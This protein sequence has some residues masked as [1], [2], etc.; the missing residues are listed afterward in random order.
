M[1]VDFPASL[2]GQDPVLLS[3]VSGD[4]GRI[5]HQQAQAVARPTTYS[6]IVRIVRF[7]QENQMPLA[8]RGQ[9][10]SAFGQAQVSQ[11]IVIDSRSLRKIHNID[12]NENSIVVDAGTTWRQVVEHTL[13]YKKQPK[14]LA[15]YLDLS[16]GGV[17]SVGG[18]GGAA[19][20]HGTVADNVL[21][22]Q[23]VTGEGQL[24]E[25]SP[26]KNSEL[27]WSVLGGLGQFGL[28]VQAKIKLCE[29][30][31]HVIRYRLVYRDLR[32]Y[33]DAHRTAIQEQNFL[34]LEGYISFTSQYGWIYRL[35]AVLPFIDDSISD[36]SR[37]EKK[38]KPSFVGVD[39]MS[40]DT[41]LNRVGDLSLYW[42]EAETVCR[43]WFDVFLPNSTIESF[44]SIALQELESTGGCLALS[45]PFLHEKLTCPFFRTPSEKIVWTFDILRSSQSNHIHINE[46]LVKN[47]KLFELARDLGGYRYPISAIPFEQ[48]DWER[49]YGELWY[50]FRERK[51]TYDPNN[52][53]TPGQ[54]IKFQ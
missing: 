27:F 3:E 40:Y 24:K 26:V 41:F 33:L 20:L 34:S 23:V 45:C 19:Q 15:A 8:M 28:I 10:H 25:C 13:M 43:P 44:L 14:V 50:Q 48:E 6:E 42:Q 31:E 38:L 11:G 29:A 12:N 5:I 52:I 49:H 37:L 22:L 18:I 9:G 30:P 54:G 32:A 51:Q 46:Q 17:L 16:V 47:R 53:L 4:F 1:I 36:K 35:E 39:R 21:A 2:V 7:A